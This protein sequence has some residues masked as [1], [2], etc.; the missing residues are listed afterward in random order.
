MADIDQYHGAA[1]IN[2]DDLRALLEE[3][4]EERQDIVD[5]I[6]EARDDEDDL[7]AVDLEKELAL[8][9]E[10]H[11]ASLIDLRRVVAELPSDDEACIREDHVE[12]YLEE[13]VNDCYDLPKDLPAFVSLKIDYDM[14]KQDYTTFD[15]SGDTYWVRCV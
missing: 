3:A 15:Y 7:L 12:N 2:S 10:E 9:D 1:Y 13:L 6:D 4:E 11:G 14:L 8:W 5:A